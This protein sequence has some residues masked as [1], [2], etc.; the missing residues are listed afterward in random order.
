MHGTNV[1]IEEE[2]DEHAAVDDDVVDSD[3]ELQEI[4]RIAAHL[5]FSSEPV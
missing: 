3:V 5:N 4:I 1:L 2:L